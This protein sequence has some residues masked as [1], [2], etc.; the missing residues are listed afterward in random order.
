MCTNANNVYKNVQCVLLN[1]YN[2]YKCIQ[3]C[4]TCI[5]VYNVHKCIQRV[6]M[7]TMC[8]NVY[9]AYNK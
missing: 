5:N 7:Y 2:V 1:V 8:T 6:Q 4:T 3:K 9:N